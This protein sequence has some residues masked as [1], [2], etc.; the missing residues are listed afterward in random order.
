MHG[1]GRGGSHHGGGQGPRH[2]GHSHRGG[3]GGGMRGG[4]YQ[5]NKF[6]QKPKTFAPPTVSLTILLK[7]IVA[8]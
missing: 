7:I 6:Q 5:N 1:G 4:K 2:E 8:T 3:H